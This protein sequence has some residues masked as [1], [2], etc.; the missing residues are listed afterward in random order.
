LVDDSA[1]QMIRPNGEAVWMREKRRRMRDQDILDDR[2]LMMLQESMQDRPQREIGRLFRLSRQY[3]NRRLT[4][5]HPSVVE[6][7]ARLIRRKNLEGQPPV[8]T[9]DERGSL[10]K[11]MRR[12]RRG[13]RQGRAVCGA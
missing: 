11:I 5:I 1:M 9:D 8:L 13:E 7:M 4:D 10:K 12:V 2:D 3:V 6:G